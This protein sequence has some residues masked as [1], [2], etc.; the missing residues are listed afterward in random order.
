[1][2]VGL[3]PRAQ[4]HRWLEAILTLAAVVIALLI[5][6]VVLAF[7]G[8]DPVRAYLHIVDSA[9]GDIGVLSDTLVKA[10]PLI[11]TGLAC[12]LA[13]RM[14][15]WNIGAEGQFLLG[16]WGAGAVVLAPVLPAG[17][18]AIIVIPA[19]MLAGA[20][21]GAVWGIIPGVLKARLGVNEIITTLMLNYIA[22]AWLQF[23]VF[24]PWSEGGF[25]QTAP[26]PR[27]AWLPRLTDFSE[28]VPVLAGLTTH[29]G[30]VFALIATAV[31]SIIVSRTRW[32]Y[33]MR[34]LG[35]NARAARYAGID[36]AKY[37]IVVFAISGALAGLAGMSEVSGV[38]HRLQDRISP[39]YGFTAIIIAYLA[40]LGPWRVVLAS[41]L[42]G[43]L[44]LAGREI[45]P[46]GVPAMIQGIILFCLIAAEVLMRYRVRMGRPAVAAS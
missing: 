20:V 13:F 29:L 22:L 8:G 15:L 23:W 1:M 37:V 44:I 7:V 30:L 45:Q 4:T 16:A 10:T 3:E 28:E 5:G 41:I 18:P 40:R 31:M 2:I 24:G 21:A 43:A 35:D 36:I 14:R 32:G 38:V 26:F 46:S 6:A 19:M 33:E 39:G 27:E 34:L 17:T 9:F 12:A 42:F 11:L 25:Q